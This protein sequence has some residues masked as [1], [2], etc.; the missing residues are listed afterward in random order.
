MLEEARLSARQRSQ[1]EAAAPA[2]W[3]QA[4][5]R[6]AGHRSLPSRCIVPLRRAGHLKHT[7]INASIPSPAGMWQHHRHRLAEPKVSGEG[8]S[9]VF[10]A[11]IITTALASGTSC[12]ALLTHKRVWL[13]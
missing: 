6:A 3:H 1:R 5:S 8:T 10:S 13:C 9:R 2:A 12:E 11:G 7:R 4:H